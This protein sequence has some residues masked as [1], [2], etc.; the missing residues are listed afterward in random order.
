MR[1]II[2]PMFCNSK[3]TLF[4]KNIKEYHWLVVVDLRAVPCHRNCR[5]TE[6]LHSTF[7]CRI[8]DEAPCSWTL[9]SGS[10]GTCSAVFDWL[11]S[12]S[13]SFLWLVT[14]PAAGHCPIKWFTNLFI[15]CFLSH[16]RTVLPSKI[17]LSRVLFCWLCVWLMYA[18][19]AYTVAPVRLSVSLFVRR[20]PPIFSK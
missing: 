17:P 16:G 8:I 13:V 1:C 11:Q 4:T 20:V 15:E 7:C 2:L 18:E 9:H 5:T 6:C 14:W 3:S 19:T 12:T 10:L